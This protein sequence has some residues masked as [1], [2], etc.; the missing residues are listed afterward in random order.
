MRDKTPTYF[1]RSYGDVVIDWEYESIYG[2]RDCIY[3][4]YDVVYCPHVRD[5]VW[6]YIEGTMALTDEECREQ[7]LEVKS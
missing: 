3:R 4:A 5:Q 7:L 2:H 6:Q 1:G